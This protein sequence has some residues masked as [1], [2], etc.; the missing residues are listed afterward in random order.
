LGRAFDA[1]LFLLDVTNIT[2]GVVWLCRAGADALPIDPRIRTR[3]HWGRAMAD[4]AQ[5]QISVHSPQN[6]SERQRIYQFRYRVLVERLGT[7]TIF[8]DRKNK[9]IRDPLDESAVHLYLMAGG[10][11]IASV[12][13]NSL[14]SSDFSDKDSE[15][16]RF[17]AFVDFKL[18]EMSMTSRLVLAGGPRQS[19]VAAVLLGAAYKVAR[20]QYS[21]FDFTSC[22]PALAK[23]YEHLG[24]R[25]FAPNFADD[26]DV[27]QVPM[28]LLT[29]DEAYLRTTKS[30]FARFCADHVNSVE[31]SQ[32]FDRAFSDYASQ[33]TELNMDD[34]KF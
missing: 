32:W 20:N 2:F 14:A 25:R 13:I 18:E 15:R 27:Y 28:V 11:V 23:L 16:F 19:Q 3:K 22:S 5:K 1:P 12:R 8:A 9:I 30:P 26:D 24:Y 33:V 17:D 6:E 34:D 29:E 31:T 21:R 10:S 7:E 4:S